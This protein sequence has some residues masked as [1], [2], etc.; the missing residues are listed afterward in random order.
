MNRTNA[1]SIGFRWVA[2]LA[3]AVLAIGG[4]GAGGGDGGDGGA[5]AAPPA[6]GAPSEYAYRQY[7][8]VI[9]NLRDTSTIE[10]VRQILADGRISESE[11][12]QLA[13][14]YQRCVAEAGVTW[15]PDGDGL[16][17]TWGDGGV[18]SAEQSQAV[19]DCGASTG[20]D[21]I[22]GLYAQM[23]VNPDNLSAEEYNA[24][25]LQ[26]LKDHGLIDEGMSNQE[27]EDMVEGVVPGAN[28]M[29]EQYLGRYIDA[30]SPDYDKGK[31]AQIAACGAS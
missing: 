30:S 23:R 19:H 4:C 22:K 27:Y 13:T 11:L 10:A 9:A 8:D 14:D 2:V 20:Y 29:Y 18:M 26:C 28:D 12:A 25:S 3:A 24:Q 16:T 31:A 7:A 5:T 21:D 6:S 1:G 17:G 15:T